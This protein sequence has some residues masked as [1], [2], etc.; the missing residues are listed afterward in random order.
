MTAPFTNR[1]AGPVR[2]RCWRAVRLAFG[3]L[4]LAGA[5][6]LPGTLAADIVINEVHYEPPDKTV[7][8]EFIERFTD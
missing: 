8:E 4:L 5:C 1:G 3:V 2:L 6:L 7:P